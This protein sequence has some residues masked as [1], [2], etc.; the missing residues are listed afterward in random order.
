MEEPRMWG[1]SLIGFGLVKLKSPTSGRDVDWLRIGFPPRKAAISV[2]ISGDI[3]SQH[4]AA[5]K[6][7][8]EMK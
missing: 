2:Y 3:L 4:G 1:T 7:L 6:F 8:R 5:L